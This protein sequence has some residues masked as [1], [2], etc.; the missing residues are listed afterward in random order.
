MSRLKKRDFL[1]LYRKKATVSL[2]TIFEKCSLS[3][4]R[5][6][7][8][9]LSSW[10]LNPYFNIKY[11]FCIK[12]KKTPAEKF[13]NVLKKTG[14]W[15][16]GLSLPVA[17]SL[18]TS[19][20]GIGAVAVPLVSEIVKK[21]NNRGF[22][23]SKATEEKVSLAFS[24]LSDVYLDDI[25]ENLTE[26][27]ST[28][29]SEIET[30]RDKAKLSV[31]EELYPLILEVKAL[32]NQ[33][34][35]QQENIPEILDYWMEEQREQLSTMTQNQ[36]EEL[37]ILDTIE[38]QLLI[39]LF[40]KFNKE[41]EQLH[42]EIAQ[43]TESISNANRS[44]NRMEEK[45]E[46]IFQE[47]IDKS[48]IRLPF[49]ELLQT[50]RIQF[51]KM[52]LAGKFGYPYNP[53]MFIRTPNLD[54]SFRNFVQQKG[55]INPVYL[56]LANIGMG[57][58]WNA[59]HLGNTIRTEESAIPFYIP[60]HLGYES[61]L[62]DVF[63]VKGTGFANKIGKK[64]LEIKQNSNKK[65]LLI[66]DGLDEYPIENRQPFIN[67][68]NQLV[69]GYKDSVLLMITD[70]IT[71]WCI[72]DFM[73]R[74][75][76]DVIKFI[77]PNPAFNNIVEKFTTI[78]PLSYYLSGFNDF[79]LNDAII[80]YNLD[81][82][83]FPNKLFELCHTPYLLRLIYER[84][85]Y[86]NPENVDEF[87]PIFYNPKERLNTIL[88]RMDIVGTTEK[89]FFQIIQFFGNAKD[90]KTEQDFI[91]NNQINSL[92]QSNK[93]EWNRIR[94]SGIIQ[95]EIRG[96]NKNYK[97]NS[98]FHPVLNRYLE[99]IGKLQKDST[100]LTKMKVVNYHGT[101]LNYQDYEVLANLEKKIGEIPKVS[102][103]TWNTFGYKVE[104][105]RIIGLGLYNKDLTSFPEYI[106][107]LV[108]LKK[109]QLDKN[110]LTSIPETIE[111][112]I[113]L[114]ILNLGHNQ[115]KSLPISISKLISL[116]ELI[117]WSNN[118]EF[119]QES[120]GN[121]T[122][123]Q[124]LFLFDNKLTKL[125]DS[126]GNLK[127][128]KILDIKQNQLSI[129]PDSIVNLGSLEKLLIKSNKFTNFP[130]YIENWLG[131]LEKKDC[132]IYR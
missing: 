4:N 22:N 92:I 56:V 123:I 74:F 132:K 88:Y 79:Q 28:S 50:S 110:N 118:L 83:R 55:I 70:R 73:L 98:L 48:L 107:D 63:G 105:N 54:K 100:S 17:V 16:L 111:K 127:S 125:P 87:M 40:D 69:Q 46:S 76:R 113:N 61:C 3:N 9:S 31:N 25:V 8:S 64:C 112:L 108:S 20:V 75:H 6:L 126:I 23:V 85:D 39:P 5:E 81:K 97:I 21:F 57:K 11:D 10:K 12:I 38:N 104:N 71:D 33:L 84:Q 122:S 26:D 86:P 129:L 14:K 121:L 117:L 42:S 116:E 66:F 93:V 114:E 101:P 82:N 24:S 72:N 89:I 80:K 43:T 27:N 109:L 91:N 53:D 94:S 59:V 15:A 106:C 29:S 120:I 131:N 99:D 34:D 49:P 52:K 18:A 130:N 115:L 62:R 1:K 103:I 37:K 102:E 124:K 67:F 30:L 36:R 77:F 68:L 90:T 44:L 45:I 78:T 119:L 128:L 47:V 95:E 35:T 51:Q 58:T 32:L 19:G 7:E 60:M 13:F 96:F 2:G 41:I 65:V